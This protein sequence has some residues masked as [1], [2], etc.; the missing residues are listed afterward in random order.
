MYLIQIIKKHFYF[1]ILCRLTIN[2]DMTIHFFFSNLPLQFFF[3]AFPLLDIFKI[4]EILKKKEEKIVKIYI[5][6]CSNNKAI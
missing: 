1:N 5:V 3:T 2:Y 6:I 4:T